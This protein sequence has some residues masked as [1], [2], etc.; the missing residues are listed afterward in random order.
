[1]DTA[2]K[3]PIVIRLNGS[4]TSR[5][6]RIPFCLTERGGTWP[7]STINCSGSAQEGCVNGM[8]M[9]G[10]RPFFAFFGQGGSDAAGV[11][12]CVGAGLAVCGSVRSA[13]CHS[14]VGADAASESLAANSSAL[15]ASGKEPE[16][17]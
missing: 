10:T 16:R 14:I 8:K 3:K 1:M 5:V 12:I 17:D 9:M 15:G 7:V 2:E 4:V 11:A 13:L 6:A